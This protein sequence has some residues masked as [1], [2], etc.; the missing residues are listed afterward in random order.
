VGGTAQVADLH[1]LLEA[2]LGKPLKEVADL[3]I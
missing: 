3:E 1:A 2:N